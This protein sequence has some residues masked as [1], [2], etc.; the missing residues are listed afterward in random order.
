MKLSDADKIMIDVNAADKVY[1]GAEAIWSSGPGFVA[2]TGGTIYTDGDYKTHV[3]LGLVDVTLPLTATGQG[4]TA[5]STYTGR[6]SWRA[7]DHYNVSASVWSGAGHGSEWLKI[8]LEGAPGA[9][10]GRKGA[11]TSYSVT[12]WSNPDYYAQTMDAWTLYGCNEADESDLTALNSQTGVSWTSPGQK[13]TYTLA[14]TSAAYRYFKIVGTTSVPNGNPSVGELELF[15]EED[16]DFIV[17]SGG[18]VEV[19]VVGGGGAGGCANAGGGGAGGVQ[20]NAAFAVTA[21]AY[22]VTVGIGGHGVAG[23]WN[24]PQKGVNG[25]DSVFDTLTALGG[26]G[27]AGFSNTGDY[28]GSNGGSGG[29]GGG[30]DGGKTR[31]TGGTGS[32]GYNGGSG[33]VNNSTNAG[34]GG[35]GAGAIGATA[36]DPSTGGAGGAGVSAYS[37]LLI[38]ADAGVDIAGTHWIAGGGGGGS[39]GNGEGAGGNGGGGAGGHSGTATAGTANTGGGGGGHG[40]NTGTGANGGSGI[41]IIKYKYK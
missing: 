25:D 27:G 40:T 41:V 11:I 18:N 24:N 33:S 14:G 29:G 34:G 12:A 4:A 20:Y 26:G 37:D 8:D 15:L 38:A 13:K 39:N 30:A 2:A 31:N 32:Q 17:I 16:S 1:L 5:S 36:S 7:F 22:S 23:A 21:Q 19:L 3:F 6:D 10:V 9:L 35:G 28:K